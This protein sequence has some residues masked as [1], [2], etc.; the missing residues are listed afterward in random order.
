MNRYPLFVDLTGRR[1][2]VV[3]GGSVATRRVRGLLDAGADVVVVA[4]SVTGD[5]RA[6]ADEGTLTWQSRRY[7]TADVDGASLVLSC[8]GDRDVDAAVAVDAAAGGVWCA[9]ADDAAASAAWVPAVGAVDDV[10]VAVSAAGDPRRARGIRDGVVSALRSGDLHARPGRRGAGE[11]VLVGGGPGD[12]DLLTLGG[13]RELLRADVVVS[14]RLGPSG[15]LVSLLPGIEVIDVGKTPRGPAARQD[16]INHLLVDRARQG[17]R[18]VRL[19][20]GDPFIYGRGGEE[21]RACVAAGV[22]VRVI[23]GVSSVSAAPGLVGIPLTQRGI[24][25]HFVVASGHVSPG[26]PRSAVDWRVLAASNG[27]LV[28]LMAVENRAAIAAELMNGGRDPATPVAVVES[29]STPRQRVAVT[30]LAGLASEPVSPPAVI[31]VGEVVA[32]ASW[33]GQA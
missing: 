3:G 19:K 23:P 21:V 6:L 8:T 10:T 11:V 9:R 28:L 27:T 7:R 14:D 18:V 4:P 32:A 1:V 13:Y 22:T 29:A 33:M 15:L 16:D 2:L 24:T 25:Q 26:D 12:P 5:V 20:G 17:Q 30:T 31:V